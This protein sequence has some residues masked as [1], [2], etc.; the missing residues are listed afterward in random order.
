MKHWRLEWLDEET[1]EWRAQLKNDNREK[2][3]EAVAHQ[4][5]VAN[6]E[7][8]WMNK[9][10]WRIAEYDMRIVGLSKFLPNAGVEPRRGSDVG[11]DPLLAPCPFC[12]STDIEETYYEESDYPTT[13]RSI[14]CSS[15]GCELHGT[16]DDKGTMRREWN[17]RAN[18]AVT[19]PKGTVDRVVGSLNQEK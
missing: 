18:P 4:V 12:G 2:F 3:D 14:G 8:A 1:G 13:L 15:C 10:K 5:D 7:G 6:R 17:H 19:G 16:Q 9:T 11:S